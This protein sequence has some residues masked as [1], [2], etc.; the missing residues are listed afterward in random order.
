MRLPPGQPAPRPRR[1]VLDDKGLS[2]ARDEDLVLRRSLSADG[3]S[4][5]FVNDQPTSVANPA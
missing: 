1:A 5:A 4:R 2:Y 3:R